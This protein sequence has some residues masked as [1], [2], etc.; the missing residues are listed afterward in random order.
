[1]IYLFSL[2]VNDGT[3][4]RMTIRHTTKAT[5]RMSHTG[6]TPPGLKR[7]VTSVLSLNG[8]INKYNP[9]AIPNQA[10]IVTTKEKSVTPSVSFVFAFILL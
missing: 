7:N 9:N 3:I 2:L 6:N 8:P 5:R 4:K 10:I 1:M